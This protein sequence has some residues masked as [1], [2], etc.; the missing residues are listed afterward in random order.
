M[1]QALKRRKYGRRLQPLVSETGGTVRRNTLQFVQDTLV[2]APAGVESREKN[3]VAKARIYGIESARAASLIGTKACWHAQLAQVRAVASYSCTAGVR[4]S[5]R[6]HKIVGRI[7]ELLDSK[8]QQQGRRVAQG[9]KVFTMSLTGCYSCARLK[10]SRSAPHL[11][12]VLS[13]RPKRL[14]RETGTLGIRPA[15]IRESGGSLELAVELFRFPTCVKTATQRRQ[16]AQ[17][18]QIISQ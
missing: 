18:K 15:E 1:A 6:E 3:R 16:K 10:A 17:A 4:F 13:N 11:F 2:N 8:V 7:E 5:F 9:D 14:S 12:A